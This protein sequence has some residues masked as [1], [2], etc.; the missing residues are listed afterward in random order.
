M[1]ICE[2][3]NQREQGCRERAWKIHVNAL[4]LG[5]TMWCTL[6]P[7]FVCSLYLCAMCLHSGSCELLMLD[8][9]FQ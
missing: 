6:F 8:H 1:L 9:F 5:H 4:R 3:I 2:G 7:P